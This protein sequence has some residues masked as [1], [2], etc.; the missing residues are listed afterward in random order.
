MANRILLHINSHCY[1]SHILHKIQTV[2]GARPACVDI[3]GEY[4]TWLHLN[5]FLK[6]VILKPCSIALLYSIANFY[7]SER[8]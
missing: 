8:W 1:L 3:I 7:Y 2:S 5:K 4:L 6:V